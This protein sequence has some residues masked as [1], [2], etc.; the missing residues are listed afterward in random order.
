MS[1]PLKVVPCRGS[2]LRPILFLIYAND[3][4]DL[5]Q[6]DVLLFAGDLKLISAK[7]NNDDLQ[8]DHQNAWGWASDWDLSLNEN[9]CGHISV[10]FVPTH[11][12]T[13]SDND[14]P[15]EFRA[16]TKCFDIPINNTFKTSM[17]V[18]KLSKEPKLTM[19]S[20]ITLIFC[21]QPL[22]VFNSNMPFKPRI[23]TSR[24]LGTS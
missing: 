16:F 10:G 24:S 14:S 3:L 6:G 4:P 15:I 1:V 18:L 23:P 13:L 8:R 2:V 9:Q 17:M 19:P 11:P 21:A 22:Y 7:A 5:L 20:S 12:L